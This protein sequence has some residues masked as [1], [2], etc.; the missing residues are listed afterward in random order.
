MQQNQQQPAADR[1]QSQIAVF[2]GVALLVVGGVFIGVAWDG[3]AS[4]DCVQCQFPYLLSG[5]IPG[6]AFIVI[7]V[8][9]LVLQTLR[10]DAAERTDQLERLTASVTE[11]VALIG[12]RDEFDP[13]LTG[14]YRPRPRV[15]ANGAGASATSPAGAGSF[16]QGS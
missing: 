5:S 3:A 10:R 12:P 8:T 13:A 4:E 16:E 14:E 11:L 2:V 9:V 7:G 1:K 15:S 6:L